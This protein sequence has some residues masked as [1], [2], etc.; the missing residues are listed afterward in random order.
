M[1]TVCTHPATTTG[2]DGFPPTT[3]KGGDSFVGVGG[4]PIILVGQEF[5]PHS[6]GS[7]THTPKLAQGSTFITVN[8]VPVGLI[9]DALDDGDHLAT[10]ATSFFTAGG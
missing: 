2:H 7:N 9:G 5:Q 4:H 10:S 6:D 8:G 3:S 1:A